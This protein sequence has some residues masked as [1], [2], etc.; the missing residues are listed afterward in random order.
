[1]I[2]KTGKKKRKPSGWGTQDEFLEIKR[3]YEQE[4]EREKKI[5][6]IIRY[7]KYKKEMSDEEEDKQRREEMKKDVK[8]RMLKRAKDEPIYVPREMR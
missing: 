7:D 4:R 6:D 8:K 2:H 3:K 5:A 1:M